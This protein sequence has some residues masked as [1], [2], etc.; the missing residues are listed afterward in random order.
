MVH[1]PTYND[2]LKM[3]TS[4]SKACTD[5]SVCPDLTHI[6]HQF[7]FLKNYPHYPETGFLCFFLVILELAL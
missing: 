1:K 7:S 3:Q 6:F 2:K 4:V 5:N